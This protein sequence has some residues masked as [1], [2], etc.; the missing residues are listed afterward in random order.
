MFEVPLPPA[1]IPMSPTPPP[2]GKT[3][4]VGEYN[5]GA[6]GLNS[7]KPPCLVVCPETASLATDRSPKSVALPVE[8]IVI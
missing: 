4:P 6:L 2:D 7:D 5:S 3:L 8:A 1:N